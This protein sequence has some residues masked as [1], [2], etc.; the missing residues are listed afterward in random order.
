LNVTDDGKRINLDVQVDGKNLIFT[1]DG[2]VLV[3]QN[4]RV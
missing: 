4:T 1:K 2:F 3:F